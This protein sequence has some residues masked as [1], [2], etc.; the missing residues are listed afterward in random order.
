MDLNLASTTV[1]HDQFFLED[2]NG[3][4]HSF[5]LQ[6]FNLACREGNSLTVVWA[7]KAGQQRGP[8][9]AVLNNTTQNRFYNEKAIDNLSSPNFLLY[10]LGFVVAIVLEFKIFSGFW[11]LLVLFFVTGFAL[12]AM[13]G[14]K[15]GKGINV[16]KSNI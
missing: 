5:Q 10:L 12:A 2:A 16:F 14:T 4:E 3:Q 15:T 11:L 7:I 1:V 13:H 8:Y 9:V 6:G